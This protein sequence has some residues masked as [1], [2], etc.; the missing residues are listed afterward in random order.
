[1][2]TPSGRETA[3]RI[4]ATT[5]DWDHPRGVG[6]T[7]LLARF[8]EAEGLPAEECLRDTGLTREALAD[9]ATLVEAHQEIAAIRN[10]LRH[11]DRPGLGTDVGSRYHLTTFGIY[12]L[13]LLSC[14]DVPVATKVALDY[15]ELSFA[16]TTI[17]SELD[18]EDTVRLTF[19]PRG[20][21]ADIRRFVA[22]RDMAASLSM[23]REM[24]GDPARVPLT[25]VHLAH[26]S[27]DPTRLED[28]YGVPVRFDAERTELCFDAAY[29]HARLPQADPLTARDAL[30]Q[31]DQLLN[32]R[33][34]RTG[35]AARVR[36]R[37]LSGGLRRGMESVAR[38]LRLSPR[39]LRRQLAQ[40]GTSY[41]AIAEEVRQ[42]LAVELIDRQGLP[43]SRVALEL[44]Y[45]DQSSF[46]RALRR[47]RRPPTPP[48]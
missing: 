14:A 25:E 31:C 18:E 29:L 20:A 15:A 10:V 45:Q 13:A 19:D 12:G 3:R 43:T 48:G 28:Y 9:T 44:G 33:R 11:L 7:A 41:R 21:P 2:P 37:L 8:A 38:E 46:L 6:G 23:Q 47:W 39:T 40:E 36:A 22:E 32:R 1:M 30:A 42:S 34:G 5:H 16:F 27:T 17:S 26:P 35:A 24:L 4:A